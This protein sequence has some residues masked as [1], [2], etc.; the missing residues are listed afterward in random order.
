MQ[1]VFIEIGAHTHVYLRSSSCPTHTF[2]HM[3]SKPPQVLATCLGYV[4]VTLHP[5]G[6]THAHTRG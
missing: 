4:A 5:G 2:T 1:P 6:V 3:R